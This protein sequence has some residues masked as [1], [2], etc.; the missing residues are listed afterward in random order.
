[1]D[2]ELQSA[3]DQAA[4]AAAT[5]LDGEEDAIERAEAAAR[6]L[7]TNNTLFADTAGKVGDLTFTFYTSYD[8]A[9]DDYGPETSDDAAAKVVRVNVGVK[10]VTYALTPITGL[11]SGDSAAT[12]TATLGAAVCKAPPLMICNPNPAGDPNFNGDY[13]GKGFLLVARNNQN[14]TY[15]PGNFGFLDTGY[16]T[17]GGAS[18]LRKA[19][20]QSNFIQE[21]A[22]S[23][24]VT[25]EP[26][27]SSPALDAVNTRFD[28]YSSNVQQNDV[29]GNGQCPP[30]ANVRKDLM[31]DVNGLGSGPGFTKGCKLTSDPSPDTS[32]GGGG[33]PKGW[34][35][36]DESASRKRYGGSFPTANAAL[37]VAQRNQ[38]YPMGL[39][40]DICH[41]FDPAGGCTAATGNS[42]MGTGTWDRAAYF[43]SNYGSSFAW[44]STSG[45]GPTVTRYQT[46]IW[47]HSDKTR[48]P[49]GISRVQSI[50][51]VTG[52]GSQGNMNSAPVCQMTGVS[53][54]A[55]DQDRRRLTVAVV[56]CTGSNAA[57]GKK[58]LTPTTWIDMFLVEPS[59]T[60]SRTT[61]NDL[62]VEII[63]KS[64]ITGTDGQSFQVERAVP[65]LIR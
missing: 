47:E 26:G 36:P 62:Y 10:S 51:N 14:D 40:R 39:P 30:A 54:P 44:A 8:Q 4:L 2:T 48:N 57:A 43:Q 31:R 41:A 38:L 7:I 27:A 37:T 15:G 35:L 46:Y 13:A 16:D 58:T 52:G 59:V 60:R 34:K 22:K 3:A 19:L 12:A 5:Q 56:N 33:G 6:S 61:A 21:C 28:I 20:G 53:E 25:T 32:P 23:D 1:M 50:P 49:G 11:L 18:S 24:L 65:Y 55:G 29:C 63:G 64:T 17:S 42:R 9:S 45:L